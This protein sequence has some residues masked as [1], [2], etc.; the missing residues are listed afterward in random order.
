MK[1]KW[2]HF[3]IWWSKRI[4][5]QKI[6]IVFLVVYFFLSVLTKVGPKQNPE[7]RLHE[8]SVKIVEKGVSGYP[9]SNNRSKSQIEADI[10]PLCREW[11]DVYKRAYGTSKNND[12]CIAREIVFSD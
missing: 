5:W 8:I 7:D 10:R 3:K 1:E 11:Y 4:L 6:L 2:E 12:S 9:Y